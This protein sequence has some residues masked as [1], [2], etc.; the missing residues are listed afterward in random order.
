MPHSGQ[1]S[2]WGDYNYL[3]DPIVRLLRFA[4]DTEAAVLIDEAHQLAPRVADMLQLDMSRDAV[5]RAAADA[6]PTLARRVQSVDRAL[7]Q[8]RHTQQ[9]SD[10]A[11]PEQLAEKQREIARPE[12]L[13][14]AVERLVEACM[15]WQAEHDQPLSPSLTELFFCCHRW[16]RSRTWLTES[17][18]RYSLRTSGRRIEVSAHCVDPSVYIAQMLDSFGPS[19]RF[20]A[21]LSPPDVYQTLHGQ[22]TQDGAFARAGS[23]FASEQQLTLVVRD[24]PTYFKQR[25]R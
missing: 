1:T 16:V 9:E 8:I 6:P 10:G 20:S 7:R 17:E 21:T 2:S 11:R 19:V 14:R 24:I 18:F 3:F 4:G 25:R 15:A 12:S 5:R 22:S 13:F 23:P